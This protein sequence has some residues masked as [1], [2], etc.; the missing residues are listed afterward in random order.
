M[1]ARTV[2]A[3]RSLVTTLALL[4]LLC[5]LSGCAKMKEWFGFGGETI[6]ASA[7]ALTV[8]AM[9]DFSTGR[10]SNALKSFQEILDRFPFG[11]QA[12]LAELKSADCQYYLGN[13]TEAKSAYQTFE[14]RH[15]TNEAIPYVMFQIGMCDYRRI[16]RLDRDASGARD[17][18]ESFSQLL[19]AYPE[20]PYTAEARARVRAAQEFLVNHEYFIATFYVRTGKHNQARGGVGKAEAYMWY[21]EH[22]PIPPQRSRSD[23]LRRHQQ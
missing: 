5:G 14:E 9:D 23:F 16:D 15:P 4:A 12:M 8:E 20:S 21:A 2:P 17:A 22:F 7:D 6:Q 19:R 11:P 13:F 1:N 3:T 10:Y 18:I